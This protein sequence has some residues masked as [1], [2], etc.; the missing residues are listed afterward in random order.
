MI[1]Q[2]FLKKVNKL[3]NYGPL[4]A[5]LHFVLFRKSSRFMWCNFAQNIEFSLGIRA[6]FWTIAKIS[7]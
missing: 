5:T 1:A 7:Y 4:E 2:S 3:G 6:N